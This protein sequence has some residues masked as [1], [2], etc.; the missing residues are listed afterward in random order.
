M[1][2]PARMPEGVR[3][4]A[5]KAVPTHAASAAPDARP[6]PPTRFG[7]GWEA[8]AVTTLTLL[9]LSFGLVTLYSASAF[10]ARS[11][12]LPD[13]H[14]VVRQAAGAVVGLF[15][16][17]IFSRIPHGAWRSLAWPMMLTAWLLLVFIVLPGTESLA[18]ERN[19]ARRW[20]LLGPASF[21]P[22]E[23]AKLAIL[24]WTA[25]MAVRKQ[26]RFRS[27]TRGLGPFL[28]VWAALLVP[29]LLEPDFSTAVLIGALGCIIVFAAGARP[30]H[31]VFL[32]VLATPVVL[33]QFA[34]DF[35]A[36]RLGAFINPEAHT[37]GAGYQ[38]NQSLIAIGS[39]GIG[40]VGFGEGQQKFGFLPEAHNDF[41]FALIGE[42]WGLIGVVALV[43]AYVALI[44]IGFRIARRAP[45]LLG[46][47]LAIGCSSLIA[48]HAFLHMGVSLSLLPATGLPL[49]LMS[50][51]R[52]NLVVTLAAIGI[53]L[54]VA[55]GI[56]HERRPAHG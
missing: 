1:S 32:G 27:L 3:P 26:D 24:V 45:D 33:H 10:L 55:R 39:G 20:L 22:S 41:I 51:G 48:L 50:D 7:G 23:A 43:C 56:P 17:L 19:G 5:A 11:Q 44:L 9:L 21:Q 34:T 29:V 35:R 15:L 37:A 46:E 53:L 28:L 13:H 12:G 18:P 54:S 38:V 14:Y 6:L 40:G 47:L 4:R 42:E 49:P 30:A 25:V 2:T 8:A 31:F 52:S 16:L 36:M